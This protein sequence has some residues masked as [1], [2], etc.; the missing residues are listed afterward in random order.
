MIGVVLGVVVLDEERRSLDS[1][2]VGLPSFDGSSPRKMHLVEACAANLFEA[3]GGNVGG[4][5]SGILF[6]E[7]IQKF[8]LLL[9]HLGGGQSDRGTHV[10]AAGI[11]AEDVFRSL[12]IKNGYSPLLL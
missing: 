4:H 8:R 5:V 3:R 6:D 2:I 12:L 7:R 9:V 1:I 11:R 10:R